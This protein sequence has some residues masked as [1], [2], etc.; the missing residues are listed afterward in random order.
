VTDYDRDLILALALKRLGIAERFEE[1]LDCSAAPEVHMKRYR[2]RVA[3]PNE[4]YA[5]TFVDEDEIE[6]ATSA[7]EVLASAVAQPVT[8]P[9]VDGT[10]ITRD[11]ASR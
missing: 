6:R 5:V 7:R 11:V 3:L 4:E 10:T 1:V 2:V 8:A 9:T